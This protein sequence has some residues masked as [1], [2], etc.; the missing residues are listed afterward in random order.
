LRFILFFVLQP[1]KMQ[2]GTIS[3]GIEIDGEMVQVPWEP[4]MSFADIELSL[5]KKMQSMP[6]KNGAAPGGRSLFAHGLRAQPMPNLCAKKQPFDIKHRGGCVEAVLRFDRMVQGLVCCDIHTQF[7]MLACDK[8]VGIG[9]RVIVA[10]DQAELARACSPVMASYA[11]GAT[12]CIRDADA[13][14]HESLLDGGVDW[15]PENGLRPDTLYTVT[16]RN[17]QGSGVGWT[18]KTKSH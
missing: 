17:T 6:N 1:K 10:L 14:V 2:C 5:A 16:L 4:D 9:D 13:I 15:C 11:H 12:L 7:E 8:L 3:L 18:F